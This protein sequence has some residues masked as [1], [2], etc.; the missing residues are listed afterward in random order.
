MRAN[1]RSQ[2]G[3]PVVM[4]VESV[5]SPRHLS[6]PSPPSRLPEVPAV[7]N[8]KPED[9][10]ILVFRFGLYRESRFAELDIEFE[11]EL[12]IELDIELDFELDF[13][14][15]EYTYYLQYRD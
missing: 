5:L 4:K 8:V 9:Q 15:V 13:E 3:K 6:P 11:F 12:D 10:E 1:N 7:L 2:P 14:S